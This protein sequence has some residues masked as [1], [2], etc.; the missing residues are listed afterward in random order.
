[1]HPTIALQARVCVINKN[2][3]VKR[4]AGFTPAVRT[5]GVKP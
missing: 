3:A 2:D 5:A 4:A 1:L